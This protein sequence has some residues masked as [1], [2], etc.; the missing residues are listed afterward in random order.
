[1]LIIGIDPSIQAGNCGFAVWSTVEK[2][3]REVTGTDTYLAIKELEQY[4]KKVK[5]KVGVMLE[6]PTLDKASF[7]SW[8]SQAATNKLILNAGQNGGAARVILQACKHL[9][10]DVVRIAPSDRTR[11]DKTSRP[12]HALKMPTKLKSKVFKSLTGWEGRTNEHGRDAAT[13]IYGMTEAKF[14]LNLLKSK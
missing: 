10:L 14:T 13:L 2:Q 7:R 3:L 11:S 1:M 6:D 4:S 8:V 5:T 9:A 12:A